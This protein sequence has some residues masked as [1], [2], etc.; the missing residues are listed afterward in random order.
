MTILTSRSS[1]ALILA[2][3]AAC[4]HHTDV[5]ET[6][7]TVSAADIG[8]APILRA[9]PLA[10]LHGD[11]GGSADRIALPRE[12]A[13]GPRG[14]VLIVASAD[15]A[16]VIFDSTG[17]PVQRLGRGGAALRVGIPVRAN[18]VSHDSLLVVDAVTRGIAVLDSNYHLTG[19]VRPASGAGVRE[20]PLTLASD[21][22]MLELARLTTKLPTHLPA[23]VRGRFAL[24]RVAVNGHADTIAEVAGDESYLMSS[25]PNREP[26]FY[27]FGRATLVAPWNGQLVVADNAS[28]ALDIRDGHGRLLQRIEVAL[29]SR[30]ATS[31]M[32]DTARAV[33]RRRAQAAAAP[34]QSVRD[35]WL[36]RI[37]SMRF[38]DTL[39]IYSSVV[40]GRDGSL[41]L[42]RFLAP[43]DSARNYLRFDRSGK[44]TGR[45][46]VDTGSA[47]VAADGDRILVRFASRT[48]DRMALLRLL[49]TGNRPQNR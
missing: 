32:H 29:S 5:P 1:A 40:T 37:D 15:S 28:A 4:A 39:P 44:L 45:L 49:P 17:L 46:A 8:G 27:E 10:V 13:L 14:E 23:A 21:S 7:T 2:L 47:L 33:E 19:L 35:G 12:A 25:D 31:G 34:S 42:E 36:I 38:A 41:W 16:L 48:S 3:T 22:S 18:W 20:L 11:S 26:P 6:I 9:E 43:G 30:L 24:V